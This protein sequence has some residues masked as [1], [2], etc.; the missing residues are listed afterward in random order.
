M[1][2]PVKRTAKKR[3][4]PRDVNQWAR[5]MVEQSTSEPGTEAPQAIAPAALSAYMAALGSEGGKISGARRM[6]N[7]SDSARSEI[8]LRAATARW[9]GER[10]KKKRAK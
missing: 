7:L 5:H 1:P 9:D 2:K 8:A 10:A 4:P 6:I 3:T